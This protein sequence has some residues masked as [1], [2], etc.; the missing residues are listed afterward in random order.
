MK[1]QILIAGK[2]NIDNTLVFNR[3]RIAF[4]VLIGIITY[5][6]CLKQ[7][8]WQNSLVFIGLSVLMMP[9]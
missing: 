7:N 5:G 6:L 1:G 3:K 9:S 8:L 4:C 2:L